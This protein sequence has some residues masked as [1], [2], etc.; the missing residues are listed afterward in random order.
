MLF[1]G[2]RAADSIEVQN[3]AIEAT[4]AARAAAVAETE[5][6]A[7]LPTATTGPT[8]TPVPTNTPRPTATKP[9][10]VAPTQVVTGTAAELAQEM[11]IT[12]Q[13]IATPTGQVVPDTGIGTL[14]AGAAGAG[15]LFLIVLVRRM[16]R[17]A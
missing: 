7:A 16:R 11:T 14:G 9:P 10:T 3:Q 4:N 15:L 2:P 13:P 5:T 1:I 12:R 8:D 6:A 17:A